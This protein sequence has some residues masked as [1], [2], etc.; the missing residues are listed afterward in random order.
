MNSGSC[1]VEHMTKPGPKPRKDRSPRPMAF[2][3]H[4]RVGDVLEARSTAL[5]VSRGIYIE[6][7]VAHALGMGEYAPELST[8]DDNGQE[9]LLPDPLH[10]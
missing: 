2:R 10:P 1:S 4:V 3:P 7:L 6:Y 9:A 8:D 5:D